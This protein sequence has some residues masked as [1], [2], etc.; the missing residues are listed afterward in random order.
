MWIFLPNA[1]LSIVDKGDPTGET[2]LV[3]GRV[4]GDIDRA[5]P[6]A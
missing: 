5:F 4:L 1:F 3:R 2:L 6:K